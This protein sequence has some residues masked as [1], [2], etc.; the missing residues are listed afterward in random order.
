MHDRRMAPRPKLF[1]L[2]RRIQQQRSQSRKTVLGLGSSEDGFHSS[3][4][5]YDRRRKIKSTLLR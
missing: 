3:E 1:V 5:N 4:T 2:M